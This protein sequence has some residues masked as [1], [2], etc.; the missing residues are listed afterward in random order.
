MIEIKEL[1]E[2]VLNQDGIVVRSLVQDFLAQQPDLSNLPKPDTDDA[3]ILAVAAALVE[4]FAMRLE[5][6]VPSW[7]GTIGPISEPIF[8][9]KAA[10]SMKRLRELCF[11]EA[12]E[13]LRRRGLY[14][15]PNYL[16]FV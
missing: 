14:A 8:L 6:E 9:V 16:E 15:P 10:A 4:L 12:P 11:T 3:R 13:P 7:T 1:A 5:Q 2:A